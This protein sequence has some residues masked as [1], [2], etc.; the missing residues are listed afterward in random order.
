MLEQLQQLPIGLTITALTIIVFFRAQ[1]TYWLGR[2]AAAGALR[3]H[4]SAT[5]NKIKRWFDGPAPK[6]GADY[7][8]RWGLIIIPLCFLTVGLQTMVN[9][10][11]GIVR[12]KWRTYTIAM[13]PG[14]IAWGVLYG[15][16]LLAIWISA[17]SFIGSK[18]WQL[19]T[20]NWWTPVIV[21]VLLSSLFVWWRA[22]RQARRLATIEA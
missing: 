16:G 3:E 5:L 7:L 10:G 19:L 12:L 6:K 20:A 2:L 21:L 8:A 18:S 4:K 9:A 14:C 15:L 1:L 13:I 11:A 17:W 22:R